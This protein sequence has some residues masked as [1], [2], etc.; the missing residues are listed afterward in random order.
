MKKGTIRSITGWIKRG[1]DFEAGFAGWRVHAQRQ[2]PTDIP[3]TI[4][5]GH[6]AR[7]KH[8]PAN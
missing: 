4:T 2:D 1:P 6:P 5:V 8:E 7:R 3:V